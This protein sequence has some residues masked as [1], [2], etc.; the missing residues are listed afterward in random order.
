MH[1]TILLKLILKYVSVNL[2]TLLTEIRILIEDALN[3]IFVKTRFVMGTYFH[4]VGSTCN[5][6]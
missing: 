4:A 3:F 2:P 1:T 6:L 5:I